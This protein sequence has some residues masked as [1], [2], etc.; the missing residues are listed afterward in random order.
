[1]NDF[2]GMGR[3]IKEQR[4]RIEYLEFENKLLFDHINGDENDL[5]AFNRSLEKALSAVNPSTGE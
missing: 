2:L 1:M 4:E 3:I 5:K